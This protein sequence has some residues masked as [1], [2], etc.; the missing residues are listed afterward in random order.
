MWADPVHRG[1]P[2][3]TEGLGDDVGQRVGA[4]LVRGAQVIP[5]RWGH[6]RVQRGQ[7]RR[8]GLRV[9]LPPYGH[10]GADPGHTQ[11]AA[12]ERGVRIGVG[13]VR[14][15]VGGDALTRL[16]QLGRGDRGGQVGQ[17]LIERDH[18]GQADPLHQVEHL[19]HMLARHGAGQRGR[20]HRGQLAQ[21]PGPLH[22]RRGRMRGHPP[23][24]HQPRPRGPARVELGQ[25]P[26][27]E[28]PQHPAQH[29]RKLME[30][31]HQHRQRRPNGLVGLL[32][33]VDPGQPRQRV[34]H[35]MHLPQRPRVRRTHVCRLSSGWERRNHS[36]RRVKRSTVDKVDHDESRPK[37]VAP[38]TAWPA[39]RLNGQP[40][41]VA[42]PGGWPRPR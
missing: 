24:G 33:R 7:Q 27:V 10:H 14:V 34:P 21:Q 19:T 38:A 40:G 36:T 42:R 1:Q 31:R 30:R 28:R 9:D 16:L 6:H 25:I 5:A 4:A 13:A 15:E 2:A 35:L 39:V 26:A 37:R 32:A 23:E 8:P 20:P 3:R 22:P 11:A 18:P 41:G 17:D 29:R 12:F